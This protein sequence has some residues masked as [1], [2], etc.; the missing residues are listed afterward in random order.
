MD[1]LFRVKEQR[2]NTHDLLLWLRH[3]LPH[4]NW[5][6]VRVDSPGDHEEPGEILS[7]Q[8]KQAQSQS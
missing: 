5:N 2:P 3:Y 4:L 7:V 1:N 6:Q 8:G